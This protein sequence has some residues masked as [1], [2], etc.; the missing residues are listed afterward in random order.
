[1]ESLESWGQLHTSHFS[2]V[3]GC[4][5]PIPLECPRWYRYNL[6][7]RHSTDPFCTLH[8]TIDSTTYL[9]PTPL[10]HCIQPASNCVSSPYLCSF[11]TPQTV[12]PLFP[13]PSAQALPILQPSSLCPKPRSWSAGIL[14]KRTAITIISAW[15][16]EFSRGPSGDEVLPPAPLAFVPTRLHAWF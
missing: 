4:S 11:P 1:M 3:I 10:S 5:Q 6:Q 15:L 2:Q 14:T 12:P 9:L 16:F 8:T 13:F 7:P